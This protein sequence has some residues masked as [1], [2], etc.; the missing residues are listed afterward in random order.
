MLISGTAL[1]DNYF[2]HMN[3]FGLCSKQL[4]VDRCHSDEWLC[5]EFCLSFIPSLP[6][7]A[8]YY[9]GCLS[10]SGYSILSLQW[11][12][13]VSFAAPPLTSA[14]CLFWQRVRFCSEG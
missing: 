9:I 12:P 4:Q 11:C 6:T 2:Q 5:H 7:C 8:I 13:V 10:V 14:Q 3:L 1:P